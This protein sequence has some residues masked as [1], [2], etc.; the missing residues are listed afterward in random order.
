MSFKLP[1]L[2]DLQDSTTMSA[3]H[4]YARLAA[5]CAKFSPRPLALLLKPLLETLDK[6]LQLFFV[7]ISIIELSFSVFTLSGQCTNTDWSELWFGCIDNGCWEREGISALASFVRLVLTPYNNPD[8]SSSPSIASTANRSLAIPWFLR[9]SSCFG[10]SHGYNGRWRLDT[11]KIFVCASFLILF[12]MQVLWIFY[13][14]PLS[15]LREQMLQAPQILMWLSWHQSYY[16][17]LTKRIG[18]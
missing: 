18:K 13:Q 1:Y 7:P 12:V 14:N 3:M 11:L 2:W 10:D 8:I 4:T 17:S 15:T 5:A 6:V 16:H 9:P